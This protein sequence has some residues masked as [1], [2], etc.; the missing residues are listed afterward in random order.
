MQVVADSGK[1]FSKSNMAL[2]LKHLFTL[3]G[4]ETLWPGL[5]LGGSHNNQD[6]ILEKFDSYLRDADLYRL[7]QTS[8]LQLLSHLWI[9][10][11]G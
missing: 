4:M 2:Q 6:S 9:D 3:C 8:S 5:D 10:P 1:A 11:M 7:I